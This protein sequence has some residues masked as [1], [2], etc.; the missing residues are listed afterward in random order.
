MLAFLI[1]GPEYCLVQSHES[2]IKPPR[3]HSLGERFF[4]QV[5]AEPRLSREPQA[6]LTKRI[7]ARRQP[8]HGR[9]VPLDIPEAFDGSSKM[10]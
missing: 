8:G 1:C 3:F 4:V 5:N 10:A 2:N 7:T 9:F 6:S